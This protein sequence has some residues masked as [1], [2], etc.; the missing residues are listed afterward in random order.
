M[1]VIDI[2]WSRVL[3]SVMG[4]GGGCCMGDLGVRIGVFTDF[5]S[6]PPAELVA[7]RVVAV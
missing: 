2:R 5:G 6:T 1:V 7:G 4:G 3:E